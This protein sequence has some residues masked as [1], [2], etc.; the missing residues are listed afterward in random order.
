[1]IHKSCYS[2]KIVHKW[3]KSPNLTTTIPFCK[4][5]DRYIEP[6]DIIDIDIPFADCISI[7]KK[8][9]TH[10]RLNTNLTE[11]IINAIGKV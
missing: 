5:C 11:M 2:S 6:E 1:M 8:L 4:N 10:A 7:I 9:G 3:F